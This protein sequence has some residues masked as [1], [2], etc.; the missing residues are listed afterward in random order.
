MSSERVE[1]VHELTEALNRGDVDAFL[2]HVTEDMVYVPRRATV[3]GEYR[4]H[5]G[6]RRFFADN[7]EAFEVF[8][9][10][11]DEVRELDDDRILL[12]G[13]VHVRGRGA[14]VDAEVPMAGVATSRGDKF[15]SWE[16][17]GERRKA[18]DAVGL[19]E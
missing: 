19:S 11:L 16:D 6:I 5:D 9:I 12:F 17:F 4:G 10:E 3:E 13:T 7:A 8:R 1:L 14:G 18:L 2:A 15:V